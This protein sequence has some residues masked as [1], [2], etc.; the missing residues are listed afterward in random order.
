MKTTEQRRNDYTR[1]EWG[2]LIGKT[3]GLVRPLTREECGQFG[4]EYEYEDAFVVVFTD[5]TA[6]IPSR[7]PE[8]NGAGYLLTAKV[9]A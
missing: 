5:G 1:R 3:V 2:S 9:K 4:W 6:I 7:D 8:L